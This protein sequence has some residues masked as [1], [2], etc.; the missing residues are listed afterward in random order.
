MLKLICS[1]HSCAKDVALQESA[2]EV[3]YLRVRNIFFTCQ[4]LLDVNYFRVSAC[5]QVYEIQRDALKRR[6]MARSVDEAIAAP[7]AADVLKEGV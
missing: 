2:C 7:S 6:Y 5:K 4:K 1:A 3:D